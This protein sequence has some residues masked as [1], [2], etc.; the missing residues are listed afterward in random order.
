MLIPIL[1]ITYKCSVLN[2]FICGFLYG[3]IVCVLYALW[4]INYR[5]IALVLVAIFEGLLYGIVFFLLKK[6]FVLFEKYSFFIQ[7]F[8]WCSFEYLRTIG[9]FGVNYGVIGYSQWNNP[10]ILQSASLFG[11]HG[12]NFILVFPACFILSLLIHNGKKIEYIKKYKFCLTGYITVLAALIIY[13]FVKLEKPVK[14]DTEKTI[15]LVQNN[16]D[17]SIYYDDKN[18]G[19]LDLY[20]K[21]ISDTLEKNKNIDL[22][23]LPEGAVRPRI[24]LNDEDSIPSDMYEDVLDYLQFFHDI[25]IP[26]VFGSTCLEYAG[27]CNDRFVYKAYNISC[28]LENKIKTIPAKIEIYKKRHLVPVIE[29]M[30]F[31]NYYEKK[32]LKFSCSLSSG[33]EINNFVLNDISFCTPICFEESFGY[34]VRRFMKKHPSFILSISSDL[35]SKSL[36]C[37]KQHL[38]MEVFRAVENRLPFLRSSVTGQTVYI[39]QKGKI[40]EMLE[41]FTSGVMT[42]KV[43]MQKNPMRTLYGVFGDFVGIFSIIVCALSFIYKI[44]MK[45]GSEAK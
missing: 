26:L 35:W 43:P 30:P 19:I 44:I 16:I 34:D 1:Y 42:V 33:K 4:L 24:L 6:S 23:V 25:D 5:T 38:A 10:V 3:I 41:P 18:N 32:Y 29:K 14:T 31:V 45:K 2:S 39:N 27:T 22:I 17:T 9:F 28:Y 20:K 37:Q 8:I 13:G 36:V 40:V 12:L 7:C 11:V 21:L 15:C